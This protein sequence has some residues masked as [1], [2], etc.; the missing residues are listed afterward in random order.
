MTQKQ[1]KKQKKDVLENLY[2]LSEGRYRE[3][4]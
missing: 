2:N 4:S 3:S 1:R